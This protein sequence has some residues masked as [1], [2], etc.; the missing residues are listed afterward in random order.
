MTLQT[1]ALKV[2]KRLSRVNA[3]G[4][5]IT[6]LEAEIKEEIGATIRY[7][8]RK[9]WHLT[10]FRGMVLTTAASQEWYSSVDL[11]SGD[12][13]QS[14]SGRSSVDTKE[15]LRIQYMRENPGSSGLNEPMLRLGYHDFEALFEG[16]TPSGPP[17]Y[18]TFYAGQIGIWPTPDDAYTL[19]LSGLVKPVI[20]T[21]DSDTSV[22]LDECEE[23]I[24]AG[25]SKRVCLNYLRD[26]ERAQEFAAVE[27][28]EASQLETEYTLKSSSGRLKAHD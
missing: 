24:V 5:A 25:A 3:T 26:Q 4:T 8:N 6:D 21:A 28:A 1:S 20:P 23:M 16:S 17:T 22:W 19:Y 7:Y 11:T 18:Y 15:I 10:E 12:G 2:A 13:D 9:P 27:L 14:N